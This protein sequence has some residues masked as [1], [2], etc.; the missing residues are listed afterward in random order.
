MSNVTLNRYEADVI[1]GLI[2]IAIDHLQ[3]SKDRTM[4]EYLLDRVLGL[5]SNKLR[6]PRDFADNDPMANALRD[7][8]E[9]TEL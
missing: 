4:A 8:G 5:R 2:A 9:Y 1:G 7:S 3:D 6:P